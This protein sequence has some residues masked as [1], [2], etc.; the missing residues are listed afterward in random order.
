M[1]TCNT[2]FNNLIK[3]LSILVSL[4]GM[5]N[6]SYKPYLVLKAIFHSPYFFYYN[7]M[8]S[9]F[10][11]KLKKNKNICNSSN[12]SFNLGI[13][14]LYFTVKFWLLYN[15]HTFSKYHHFFILKIH[16]QYMN[17]CSLE[18]TPSILTPQF[19]FK[20]LL[21]PQNYFYKLVY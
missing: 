20:A 3:V 5:T 1:N 17:S 11:I 13:T 12:I 8:I 14:C 4:K 6:H 9:I 21:F 7:M 15:Q 16:E 2:W 18:C 10:K 19:A